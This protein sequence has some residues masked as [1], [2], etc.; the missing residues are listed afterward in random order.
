MG[1]CNRSSY[2][3]LADPSGVVPELCREVCLR[4]PERVEEGGLRDLPMDDMCLF[5]RNTLSLTDE[6]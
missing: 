2:R 5:F 3:L 1:Y 4:Q 6:R